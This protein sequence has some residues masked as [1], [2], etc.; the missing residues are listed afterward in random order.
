MNEERER[1]EFYGDETRASAYFSGRI[2]T[3][4][5]K[6]PLAERF[7]FGPE[8]PVSASWL[9]TFGN[10]RF[11]GFVQRL[12]LHEEGD[13]AGED[14]SASVHGKLLHR[15]LEYWVQAWTESEPTDESRLAQLDGALQKAADSLQQ[16]QPT[17]H[18]RLWELTIE[19]SKEQLL[20]LWHRTKLYTQSES[21]EHLT[22]TCFG[23]ATAPQSL[24]Q[25]MLPAAFPHEAPVYLH[26]EID[27]W[28]KGERHLVVDYKRAKP[29]SKPQV[30]REL[31]VSHFQLPI[32][33]HA[34]RQVAGP[35][36]PLDAAWL[37]VRHAESR[38]L[39]EVLKKNGQSMQELLATDAETRESLKAD[40]KKNL[41]NAVHGLLTQL[42]EGDFGARP[43]DCKHCTVKSVCRISARVLGAF[44]GDE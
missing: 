7:H 34:V 36:A 18:P 10:C 33:L 4:L 8:H 30:Y 29:G 35:N 5:L 12:L 19:R 28:D 42:R 24:T 16:E 22:E 31:G 37:G 21:R 40:D 17:G 15:A 20:R 13:E 1:L 14:T 2:D 6:K 38:P 26:G 41:A 11:Q 32:Y 23:K 25:V 43:Q 44:E 3:R 27:R 9:E 39:S